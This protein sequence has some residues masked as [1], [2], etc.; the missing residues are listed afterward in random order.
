M[1][2]NQDKNCFDCIEKSTLFKVLN[3]EELELISKNKRIVKFKKGEIIVKQ[4]APMSHVI[5]FTS[6]IAK[7]Y[8]EG[9][10]NRNLVLQLIKPTNFLGAP[11][12]YA[13]QIHYSTVSAVEDS[14]VCFIDIQTFKKIIGLNQNFANGFMELISRN[15]IFNY[16]RFIC[17]TQKNIHGRLADTLI[18]LHEK[19][20][21]E[22]NHEISIS[23]NDLSELTGMSKDSI[24]RILKEFATEKIIETKSNII[25]ILNME[26]LHKISEIA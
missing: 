9:S 20:F 1:L 13:N 3:Q 6:G 23:R 19:I 17:L 26:K 7:V 24:I 2:C 8:I 4:G 22:R 11:G 18:Y 16:E 12:I 25:R 14:T 5:S 10:A 21:D 15:G